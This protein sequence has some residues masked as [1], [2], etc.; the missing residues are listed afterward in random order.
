MSL[1]DLESTVRQL[2]LKIT[3]AI[4]PA[5]FAIP[6][7]RMRE[8]AEKMQEILEEDQGKKQLITLWN[9]IYAKA[10][11]GNF[12]VQIRSKNCN[13]YAVARLCNEGYEIDSVDNK[14][15][16]ICW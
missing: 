15:L 4:N 3:D 7:K 13:S 5:T 16:Q 1:Q 12:S 2:N 14:H 11:K 8:I 9:A 10:K 6:A